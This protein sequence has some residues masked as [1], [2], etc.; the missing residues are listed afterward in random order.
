MELQTDEELPSTSQDLQVAVQ[1][2][3][4]TLQA[5]QDHMSPPHPSDVEMSDEEITAYF[6]TII[7]D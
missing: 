2:F 5:S 3:M 7:G 1:N 4:Q 6:S